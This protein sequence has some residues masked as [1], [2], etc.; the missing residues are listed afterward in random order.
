MDAVSSTNAG[1]ERGFSVLELTIALF[2]FAALAAIAIPDG[3]GLRGSFARAN[4][5]NQ[6]RADLA[7][8]RSS[9]TAEGA[10][11]S[12]VVAADGKSYE[13]GYDYMPYGASPVIERRIARTE[14]PE[15]VTISAS[16]PLMFDSRGYLITAAGAQT[17]SSVTLRH[18]GDLF[19]TGTVFASGASIFD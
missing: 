12:I 1:R 14:L 18:R 3:T 6:F 13:V 5:L 19:G 15:G 4:G 17:T 8:A 9:A 16:V 7:N 11:T 2:V 10:R